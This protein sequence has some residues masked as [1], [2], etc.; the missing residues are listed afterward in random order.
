MANESPSIPEEALMSVLLSDETSVAA[1]K[2]FAFTSPF[3]VETSETVTAPSV[4]IPVT[5]RVPEAVTL[6]R[7]VAPVTPRVPEA[8]TLARD[9]APVTPRVFTCIG[10]VVTICVA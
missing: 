6:A 10:C 8:V 3:I 4:V 7:D 5:P 1:E 9:V 2:V